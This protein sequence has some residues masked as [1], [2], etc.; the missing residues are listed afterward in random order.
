M[1]D[2]LSSDGFLIETKEQEANIET[3]DMQTDFSVLNAQKEANLLSEDT[4]DCDNDIP[5]A[6]VQRP[7]PG[8][9]N[10]HET[11]QPKV[12]PSTSSRQQNDLGRKCHREDKSAKTDASNGAKRSRQDEELNSI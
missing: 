1:G 6:Q 12:K 5:S 9:S 8:T 2:K 4:N 11:K 10:E 7:K 3:E